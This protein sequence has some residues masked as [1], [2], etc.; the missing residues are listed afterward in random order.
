MFQEGKSEALE[1]DRIE[2]LRVILEREQGR[3]IAYDEARE[4][5]ES[6]VSFFEVLALG[7]TDIA[8]ASAAQGE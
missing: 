5:G 8:E 6:L 2:S 3:P 7:T 4:I 1:Q